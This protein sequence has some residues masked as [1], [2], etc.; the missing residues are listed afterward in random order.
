MGFDPRHWRP[1]PG[2]RPVTT[3]GEALLA[4]NEALRRE[5]RALRLQLELLLQQGRRPAQ[6]G[7]AAEPARRRAPD[8]TTAASFGISAALVERWGEALARHPRWREL[9][10]GPPGGL[11]D[12]IAVQQR[13]SWNPALTLEQDLDRRI[14]GLGTELGAALRGPHSRVRWA[15]RAAFAVYGPS[16]LEWLGDEPLRVVEELLRRVEQL[17]RRRSTGRQQRRAGTRTGNFSD[18]AEP[19]A[20][21][22]GAPADPRRQAL[23]L[24]GL[25]AG[26]SPQ[27]IKRAYRRL[28]KIHHPDLG[29]DVAL[30]HRLDAAYRLLLS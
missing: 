26:A 17:E 22:P 30:F 25:E 28:A 29:G 11:R 18:A 3:N 15:V 19:A 10:I 27:A 1:A 8:V 23:A 24:L 7:V 13:Q 21:A 12:L 9:R 5:V 2:S 4:E 16:A 14:P 20:R 6:P